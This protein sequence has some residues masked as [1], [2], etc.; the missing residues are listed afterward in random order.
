MAA[1][2]PKPGSTPTKVPINTPIKQREKFRGVVM[3]E[4][5]NKILLNKSMAGCYR[6]RNGKILILATIS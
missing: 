6:S 5:P 2:G 4:N 1:E 3:V